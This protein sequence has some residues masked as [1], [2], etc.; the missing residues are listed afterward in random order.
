MR[1]RDGPGVYQDLEGENRWGESPDTV[2]RR[3]DW[4]EGSMSLCMDNGIK[5]V[6]RLMHCG[7]LIAG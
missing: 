4:P 7:Y 1:N 2:F 3:H 5:L 6:T